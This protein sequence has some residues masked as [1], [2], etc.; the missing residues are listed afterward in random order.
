[1]AKN[2]WRLLFPD[3]SVETIPMA[4]SD[5]SA[6]LL[7][8][9]GDARSCAPRRDYFK[10]DSCWANEEQC[11]EIMKRI[12]EKEDDSFSAKVGE[13]GISLGDWQRSRRGQAKREERRLRSYLL[14]LDSGSVMD[15][16]CELRRK[17]LVD[18]KEIMDKDENYWLQRSR[19]AWLKDGDRNSSFFHARANRRRK[20]NWIEGL[21][22]DGGLV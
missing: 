18:L 20:K 3:C 10:F 8:L 21:Q 9:E 11:R 6:I 22:R 14:R 12:W 2:D 7:K 4:L 19:V 5:H 1:M 16:S 17:A 15:M 13:I